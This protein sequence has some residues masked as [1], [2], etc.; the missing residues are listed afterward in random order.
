MVRFRTPS[1]TPVMAGPATG[2]GKWILGIDQAI[3]VNNAEQLARLEAL[4]GQGVDLEQDL[5]GGWTVSVALA[6]MAFW[7]RR[8]VGLLKLWDG[9][10]R[11]PDSIY[12]D[13]LNDVLLPEWQAIEPRRS[14][15]L[16]V[17][18]ARSVNAA[19]EAMDGDKAEAI[20]MMGNEFMLARGS[21][22]R[23][24]LDQIEEALS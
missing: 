14:A 16:A 18:A 21:H 9:E 3:L 24:H 11:L 1:A 20:S 4:V 6:H 22:R 19:V 2:E 12:E 23:E 8:A 7:D 17:E 13:E 15:Q 10:G 5:G